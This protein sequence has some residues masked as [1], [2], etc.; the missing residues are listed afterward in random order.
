MKQKE[1]NILFKCKWKVVLIAVAYNVCS[2]N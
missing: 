1:K 2:D